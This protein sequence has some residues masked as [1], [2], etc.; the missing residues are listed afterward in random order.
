[1]IIHTLP[2]VIRAGNG[3][4]ILIDDGL[5][6]EKETAKVTSYDPQTGKGVAVNHGDTGAF[7]IVGTEGKMK[8]ILK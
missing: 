4:A 2:K 6:G 1:M 7:Q 3:I 8:L 5:G